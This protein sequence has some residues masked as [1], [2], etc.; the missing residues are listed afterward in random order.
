MQLQLFKSSQTVMPIQ[1]PTHVVRRKVIVRSGRRT[2]DCGAA[3]AVQIL[4]D[5]NAGS[6]AHSRGAAESDREGRASHR[7]L[8]FRQEIGSVGALT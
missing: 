4:A 5:R 8:Q 1:K 2:A 7:G 6:E 3:I